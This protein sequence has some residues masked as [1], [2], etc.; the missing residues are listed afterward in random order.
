MKQIIYKLSVVVFALVTT[1]SCYNLDDEN[2]KTLT[3]ITVNDV[4]TTIDV[5]SGI[6]LI[7]TDLELTSDLPIEYEW[8][9]GQ[10]KTDSYNEYA[11]DSLRVIS[12]DPDIRYTFKSLGT[13]ILR[14][15]ADNGEDVLLKYFT[16]NV[17]SGLDEGVLILSNDEEE[18]GSLTLVK[19]RTA[20]EIA[21]DSQEVF[22]DI[23]STI[24]PERSLKKV[25]NMYL[26]SYYHTSSSVYYNSLLVSTDDESGTLYK[27]EPNTL[28]VYSTRAM[29]EELGTACEQFVGDYMISSAHYTFMRGSDGLT[30]RYDLYSDIIGERTDVTIAGLYATHGAMLETY[31]SSSGGSRKPLMFSKE[32]LFVPYYGSIT[33]PSIDG[34]YVVNICTSSVYSKAYVLLQSKTDPTSYTIRSSTT[35][36]GTQTEV[37]TFSTDNLCMDIDSKMVFTK[38]SADVYY[39]FNNGIYRWTPTSAPATAPKITLPEGEIIRDIE[40]NYMAKFG[41]GTEETLLYVATYNPTREGKK[42]SLYVYQ[43]SDDQL[44]TSYEGICDDPVQVMYKYRV[45]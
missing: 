34:Y 35:S 18:N 29:K 25:K 4:A 11:M 15:K 26:S 43:F 7:Y 8:A 16:L 2:F 28:M 32:V 21:E 3:P 37:I 9:Y 22:T 19:K 13:F 40:T 36:M 31:S 14:L 44:V 12:N 30:Y 41:D 45:Q 6:E 39:T 17:N 27:M 5:K 23:F 10:V 1:V 33:R 24:N 20:D 42:G 38:N